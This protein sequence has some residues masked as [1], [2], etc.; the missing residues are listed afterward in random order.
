M[1][2]VWLLLLFYLCD[3][4]HQSKFDASL[5]GR[6]QR[7]IGLAVATR[8]YANVV[9]RLVKRRNT[10]VLINC[11]FACVVTCQCERNVTVESL[12]QPAQVFRSGVNVRRSIVRI[13]ATE[14]A[15]GGWHQLHQALCADV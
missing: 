6:Q 3:L 11:A 5:F 2:C 4:W 9:L 1:K 8:D 10:L 14:A 12:K 7:M 15:R 13:V